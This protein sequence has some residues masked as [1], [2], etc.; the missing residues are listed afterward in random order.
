MT[1]AATPLSTG[2]Y[3]ASNSTVMVALQGTSQARQYSQ[4]SVINYVNL[5]GVGQTRQS[6]LVSASVAKALQGFSNSQSSGLLIFQTTVSGI[7]GQS[8]YS[9][10]SFSGGTFDGGGLSNTS[11]AGTSSQQGIGLASASIGINLSGQTRQTV[12]SFGFAST[13]TVLSGISNQVSL[14]AATASQTI[15]LVTDGSG[16]V[17]GAY[18]FI[19]TTVNISGAIGQTN[20]GF[21][22]VANLVYATAGSSQ[23]SKGYAD[24]IVITTPSGLSGQTSSVTGTLYNPITNSGISVQ[25]SLGRA[26]GVI[27]TWVAPGQSNQFGVMSGDLLVNT[28]INLVPL[29]DIPVQNGDYLPKYPVDRDIF[30]SANV[31]GK[32]RFTYVDPLSLLPIKLGGVDAVLEITAISDQYKVIYT[33]STATG[34]LVIDPDLGTITITFSSD[35]TGSLDTFY[36]LYRLRLLASGTSILILKG[37]LSLETI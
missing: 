28:F 7:S 8:S 14:L 24:L 32:F 12:N 5:Q 31:T 23:F 27:P 2:S 10:F 37:F 35:F 20:N 15:N 16:Q 4:S 21:G 9:S 36:G 25:N 11:L 17:S 22:G 6:N 18:S 1:F 33:L 3:S 13:G 26:T 29:I 30:L 19:L 34:E